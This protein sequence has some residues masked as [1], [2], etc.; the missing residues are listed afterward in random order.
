MSKR[1]E[2]ALYEATE[3]G[4]IAGL[5]LAIEVLQAALEKTKE[6]FKVQRQQREGDKDNAH[7]SS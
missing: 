1:I 3:M 4:Y 7:S 2:D 6:N 5:E